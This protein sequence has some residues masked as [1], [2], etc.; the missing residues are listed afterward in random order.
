MQEALLDH[1]VTYL[2]AERNLAAK[3]VEAYATDIRD[4]LRFLH[5][6]KLPVEKV[7]REDVL[8]HMA[9]LAENGLSPRSRARHLAALRGFHRFLEDEKLSPANPTEDLDT[10]KRS[11]VASAD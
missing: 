9:A 8:E 4:Y 6:Q 1:Y 2:R 3:T 5:E 11:A 7:T 10:P